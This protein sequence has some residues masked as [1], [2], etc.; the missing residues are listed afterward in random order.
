[1]HLPAAS[2]KA[3]QSRL[4]LQ[5]QLRVKPGASKCR[6]GISAVGDDAIELCVAAQARDGEANQAVI[7]VLSEVLGLPK[8]RFVLSRGMKSRDK[9]VL[10]QDLEGDG[11]VHAARALDLLRQAS[12]D[13]E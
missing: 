7:R 12:L 9:T 4:Q 10:L 3:S 6:E 8:S 2:K 5:L 1:M 11:P 13:N